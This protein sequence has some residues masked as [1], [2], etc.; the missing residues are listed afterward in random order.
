MFFWIAVI[1]ALVIGS[2]MWRTHMM[3]RMHAGRSQADEQLIGSMQMEINRLADRVKV[4]ERLATDDE[5]NL[6]R[7]IDS[8]RDRPSARF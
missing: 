7:E 8:L 5:R 6:T 3:T 4:L 1:V 2:R